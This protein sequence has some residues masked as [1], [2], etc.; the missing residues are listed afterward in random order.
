M[1]NNLLLTL[2]F[3]VSINAFAGSSAVS[4]IAIDT[5][6]GTVQGSMLG[7]R[8]SGDPNAFIACQ[9]SGYGTYSSV[10]GSS[11]TFCMAN[12][13]ANGFVYCWNGIPEVAEAAASVNDTSL[14]AFYWDPATGSTGG[15][16]TSVV[17]NNASWLIE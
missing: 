14:I 15:E 7:A 1:K 17:I 13:T 8:N 3:F 12:T 4:D 16:C 5:A 10:T 11:F 6:N 2:L 9:V